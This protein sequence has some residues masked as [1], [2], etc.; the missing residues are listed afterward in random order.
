MPEAELSPNRRA[1]R[2]EDLE[3]KGPYTVHRDTSNSLL[4]VHR[5][6]QLCTT[7]GL[8]SHDPGTITYAQ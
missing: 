3:I 7:P 6:S 4:S 1:A 2:I 5:R 8:G